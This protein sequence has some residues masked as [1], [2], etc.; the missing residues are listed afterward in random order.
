MF[1]CVYDGF[2]GGL[3]NL[4][5]IRSLLKVCAEMIIKTNSDEGVFQ[6]LNVAFTPYFSSPLVLKR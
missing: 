3:K 6:H 1:I 2:S 5:S 4:R